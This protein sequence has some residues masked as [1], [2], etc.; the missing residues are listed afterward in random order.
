MH[1]LQAHF[2][3]VFSCPTT[4]STA[5]R[6][7]WHWIEF[8]FF[9]F[10]V[11]GGGGWEG[12]VGPEWRQQRG[13]I[14][15]LRSVWIYTS[16]PG[17]AALGASRL[18]NTPILGA[19]GAGQVISIIRGEGS[20]TYG[21]AGVGGWGLVV[22]VGVRRGVGAQ[23]LAAGVS[24]LCQGSGFSGGVAA[25]G[26]TLCSSCT[27][28][29]LRS[30]FLIFSLSFLSAL[31]L[32]PYSLGVSHSL[33]LLGAPFLCV[34]APSPPLWELKGEGKREKEREWGKEGARRGSDRVSA[35]SEA[36]HHIFVAV[37]T[38]ALQSPH[39]KLLLLLCIP[40]C[41]V[42]PQ[43]MKHVLR[44][45]SPMLLHPRESECKAPYKSS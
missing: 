30:L 31:S 37:C 19:A 1:M 2:L 17:E 3:S 23:G 20:H 42:P 32:L 29:H 34:G 21:N 16:G 45:L 27:S 35:L 38:P 18:L 39:S 11:V 24:H 15:P 12:K 26:D 43:P 14:C 33:T 6:I 5:L 28:E 9:F 22:W 36:F 4:L 10:G 40:L 8:L 41:M 13:R 7:H 44:L 25:W